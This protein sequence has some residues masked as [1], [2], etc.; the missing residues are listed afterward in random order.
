MIKNRKILAL[1]QV[2]LILVLVWIFYG[3]GSPGFYFLVFLATLFWRDPFMEMIT[4]VRPLDT[5][6]FGFRIGQIIYTVLIVIYFAA[7]FAWT[8]SPTRSTPPL[9]LP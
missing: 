6:I 5:M 1:V 7:T 8:W 9:S 3:D 4:G 2:L